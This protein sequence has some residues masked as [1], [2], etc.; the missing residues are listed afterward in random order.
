MKTIVIILSALIAVN[1]VYCDLSDVR[2]FR[3]DY[4]TC[5]RMYGVATH[6]LRID[7]IICA[8]TL[9]GE[10]LYS[11]LAYSPEAFLRK[12]Q[13][14]ISD[15]VKLQQANEIFFRCDKEA[16]QS[17]TVNITKTIQFLRCALPI[18]ILV[19]K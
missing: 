1:V 4:E 15:P 11:N 17:G 5:A 16:V 3:K 8:S 12:L 7:M 19:D 9:D 2:R 14:W 13:E 6:E 18:W 10:I